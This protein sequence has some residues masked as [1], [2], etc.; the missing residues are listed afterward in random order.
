MG[1]LDLFMSDSRFSAV[2]GSILRSWALL[3]E[4]NAVTK[5]QAKTLDELGPKPRKY[6]KCLQSLPLMIDLGAYLTSNN[7]VSM[8]TFFPK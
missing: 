5:S 2:P 3:K 8:K 1:V 6:V 4:T 7:A